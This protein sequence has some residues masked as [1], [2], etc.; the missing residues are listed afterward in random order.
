MAVK[1]LA[2]NTYRISE[3]GAFGPVKMYLLIG[4]ER[5]LLIDSGYGKIISKPPITSAVSTRSLKAQNRSSAKNSS[6]TCILF[7]KPEQA[8]QGKT[9]FPLAITKSCRMRSAGV[10]QPCPRKCRRKWKDCS[11]SITTRKRW[12]LKIS[13]RSMCGAHPPIP[14]RQRMNRTADPV[15]GMSETQYCA[16]YYWGQY[17]NVLLPWTAGMGSGK[18]LPDRHLP[19]GTGYLQEIPGLFQNTVWKLKTSRTAYSK[20]CVRFFCKRPNC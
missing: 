19:V 15:Q 2:E 1:K 5:A 6:S 9:G 17:K 16:V 11:M 20:L 3:W 7:W 4:N 14:G 10:K 8:T 12:R 18:R 13:L